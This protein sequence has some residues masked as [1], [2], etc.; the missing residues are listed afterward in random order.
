MNVCGDVLLSRCYE[1]NNVV[2]RNICDEIF[3]VGAVDSDRM[4]MTEF[5]LGVNAFVDDDW[6]C[7][8]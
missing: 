4:L 8:W 1:R 3:V 5:S 2:I 6:I 7:L